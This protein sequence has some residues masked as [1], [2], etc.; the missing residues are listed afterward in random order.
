MGCSAPGGSTA[1]LRLKHERARNWKLSP[2][3]A[4]TSVRSK[5]SEGLSLPVPKAVEEKAVWPSE[6]VPMAS[7]VLLLT[8]KPSSWSGSMKITSFSPSTLWSRSYN[9][10][11]HAG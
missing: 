6:A 8:L 1:R 5:A 4:W 11:F 9:A 7:S 10:H 2:R 3:L